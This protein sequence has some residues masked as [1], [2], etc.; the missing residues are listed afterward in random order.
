MLPHAMRPAASDSRPA[1]P[2]LVVEAAIAGERVFSGQLYAGFAANPY[3][4]IPLLA[5]ASGAI[6][7][8]W[9]EPD[10]Q[11][12]TRTGTLAVR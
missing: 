9:R 12:W 3:L 11:S 7:I 1:R 6:A 8:S 5:E 4:A 2:L 10:G